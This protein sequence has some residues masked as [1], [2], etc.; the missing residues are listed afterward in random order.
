MLY[1]SSRIDALHCRAS[2]LLRDSPSW[3]E[4]RNEKGLL[5]AHRPD[6]RLTNTI[7]RRTDSRQ[8]RGPRLPR[9]H[10]SHSMEHFAPEGRHGAR[11]CVD[12]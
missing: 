8:A 12:E 1:N 7:P 11:L 2:I 4:T 5:Q 3:L 6:D 9:R 10:Q